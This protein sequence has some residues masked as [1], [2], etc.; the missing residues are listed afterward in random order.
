MR[1]LCYC[2]WFLILAA[3]LRGSGRAQAENATILSAAASV[4]RIA[5]GGAES[6]PASGYELLP[7]ED[8][9]NRMM[10]PFARHLVKDQQQFWTTPG[11]LR[12][13]DLHWAAP[14][15]GMTAML[16]A[17]DSWI[18]KQVPP[19]H[20]ESS[21]KIS[22]YAV[23]SLAGMSAGSFLLGQSNGNDRLAETGLLSGEAAINSTATAYLLKMAFQR[24][25]PYQ[26][27]GHGS[28]FRGGSGFPSE[29]AAV[30]WAVASVWAHEYPSTFSQTLA[31]GLASAVTVTRVTGKQHFASDAL[32]GSAL[33]WYFARQVYRAHSDSDLGGAAWGPLRDTEAS[34]ERARPRESVGSPYVPIDSWIYPAFDRL[35]ALGVVQD[36]YV[37]IRPWTRLECARLV[38]EAEDRM[39]S[40]E[41]GNSERSADDDKMVSA[42]AVEFRDESSHLDGA[43]NTGARVDSVYV[44]TTSISGTPLRDGYHFGQ[45]IIN[46][47]GRPYGESFNVISGITA[48][49]ESG[50]FSLFVQGEYQHA[51]AV[52][53]DAPP[54]LAATAAVDAVSPVSDGTARIDRVRLLQGAA[55][56]TV[57]GIEISFGQ[58]SLWL[59]P[60]AAGP[61]LFSNNAAPMTMLRVDSVTPYEVPWLSRLLGPMRSQFFL[62]RFSGQTWEFTPQ[63]F[64][65]VLASQPFLHGTKFSFHPTPNLEFGLGFTAQ[66]GG[67]GN[68]FTWGN[69]L[70]TFY[71]HRVGIQNNPGKRLSEFDFSYRLPGL[72]DWVQVYADSMVIDEYSPLGSGRPAINPGIYL[73]RLPKISRIELRAEGV[74]T[75]LNVPTHFGSGAFYWDARYRSGYTNGGNLLGSWVGRRGRGEQAWLTY[76]LSPRSTLALAYRHNNVDKG[77]LEGG[78]LRDWTVRA[79]LALTRRIGVSATVEQERWHFPVL[80]AAAQSDVAA[81]VQLSLWPGRSRK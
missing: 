75:D 57:N 67:T 77:F 45:T 38:E 44:R 81:S 40:G 78:T 32:I 10:A 52:A 41:A 54:T 66:F 47:Y 37:G 73:A 60:G 15:A 5:A 2:I 16:V 50:P 8:P 64:G 51:P 49:A 7:G 22:N 12:L 29:H 74:T 23:Y 55:A 71:S 30:A 72:R 28:F 59:G 24:Q 26:G 69:F 6:R 53:S 46:D 48:H 80:L 63:L 65:P 1:G 62:G 19:S 11:R 14:L 68:P 70:R 43:A 76:H 9:E 25:R 56:F 3:G 39:R 27:T 18:S 4:S 13:E 21:K 58:Q 36:A 33:G 34:R 61:F 35:I 42:L 20:V 79:D 17:S 31:Y